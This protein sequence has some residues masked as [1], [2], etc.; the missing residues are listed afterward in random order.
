MLDIHIKVLE[1][2]ETGVDFHLELVGQPDFFVD[3]RLFQHEAGTFVEASQEQS[4]GNCIQAF[5]IHFRELKIALVDPDA[6][7]ELG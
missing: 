2:G 1:Q 3:A 5:H 4:P 6:S 7:A